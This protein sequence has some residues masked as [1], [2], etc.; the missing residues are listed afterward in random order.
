MRPL[1]LTEDFVMGPPLGARGALRVMGDRSEGKLD[2]H[3][4]DITATGFGSAG[5]ESKALRTSEPSLET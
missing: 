5:H 2:D 4:G 3:S 1:G